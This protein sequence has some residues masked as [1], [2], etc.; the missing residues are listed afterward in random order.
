MQESTIEKINTTIN[1]NEQ[2]SFK[3]KYSSKNSNWKVKRKR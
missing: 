3:K 1:V 2:L